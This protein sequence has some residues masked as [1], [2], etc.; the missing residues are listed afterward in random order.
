[1]APAK[2]AA[3]TN[4]RSAAEEAVE[5]SAEDVAGLERKLN[6]FR[7]LLWLLFP[8]GFAFQLGEHCLKYDPLWGTL[9][10]GGTLGGR[11][12]DFIVIVPKLT[13]KDALRNN[14]LTDLGITMF[15][16]VRLLRAIDLRKA[17]A[18]F[19]LFQFDDYGHLR[20]VRSLLRW[21]GRGFR[22][23]FA[24]RLPAPPA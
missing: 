11:L 23:T 10:D 6:V 12:G 22:Y 7:W 16:R 8:R 1:M 14:H 13:M 21:L 15:V 19:V 5:I 9:R 3:L 20:S 4:R 18:L 2:L 24:L 17:Y